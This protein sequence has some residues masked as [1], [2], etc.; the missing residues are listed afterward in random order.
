MIKLKPITK[1]E[2]KKVKVMKKNTKTA[3]AIREAISP[4]LG[5]PSGK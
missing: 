1:N 5:E 4:K 2:K 3:R